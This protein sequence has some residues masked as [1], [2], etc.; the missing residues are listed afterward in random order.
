MFGKEQS[1]AFLHNDIQSVV[2]GIRE[3]SNCTGKL[4]VI[5][6]LSDLYSNIFFFLNH[7]KA[8][9]LTVVKK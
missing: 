6:K 1:L 2:C 7:K 5:K 9:K 3:Y 4:V 8:E